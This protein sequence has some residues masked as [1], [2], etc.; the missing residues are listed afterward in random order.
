MGFE[1]GVPVS[2]D[3]E[4][5][6]LVELLA[7]AAELGRRHGIGIVDHVE[8]RIVGLKIRDVYEVPAAAI[9]LAAH[10]DLEELVSTIHQNNFKRALEDKWAYLCYAG[11]WQEPLRSDLDA[12]MESAN[13]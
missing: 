3:G 5:L 8:D 1:R 9:I 4:P 13:E 12:Y 6:G 10:R 11:L 7:R 2:I